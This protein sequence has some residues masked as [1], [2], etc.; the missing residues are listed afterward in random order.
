MTRGP[1]IAILSFHLESNAF[2]PPS[3]LEDFRQ[4]CWLEGE[5][6]SEHARRL[7]HMPS[8]ITGFYA[9]M[10]AAGPWQPLPLV[11]AAAPPGGPVDEPTWQ[12]FLDTATARLRAALPVD[13][14]YLGNHGAASG[15]GQGDTEAELMD[16]VRAI[17]GPE[18]PLIA[19]YDLHCNISDRVIHALDGLF[20]YR[21]NP[22]VDLRQRAADAA[23]AILACLGG[24]RLQLRHVRLPFTPPS[25]T[26]LTARGP[27]ADAIGWADTLLREDTSGELVDV[28][29]TGGFVFSDVPQCGMCVSVTTRGDPLHAERTAQAL[30]RRIWEDRHRYLVVTSTVDEAVA[31][32]RTST[33]PLLF[34][35]VADNPGGGGGGNTV[36]LMK[37]FHEARI[38]GVVLGVFIDADAVQQAVAAGVGGTAELV[39]NRMPSLFADTYAAT[40]RV[41]M[42]SDGEGTGRR[43]ILKDRRFSLGAS[44]LVEL[45]PSG[46]RVLVSSLRR[47]LSEP[48]MLEMHGI[49][50]AAA[51]VLIV[52]SRGH[53]RAGFDE[54][55]SDDRIVDVDSDGL[56]TP[57]LARVPFRHLPRPV[58]PLDADTAWPAS[59]G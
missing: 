56:T 57:N 14:V 51:R 49:D 41:L 2:S 11:I 21:T 25:V 44:A 5:A 54:F 26:L 43:G 29:V 52:K 24:E 50:I 20:P 38:P 59:A 35:D 48:A 47:Q 42:L 3:R 16:A 27:F 10:D 1:R 7:N 9:R 46:M 4:L 45:L 19:S 36:G 13:A 32:A 53:Y 55:F 22:H 17:V 58:F 31:Q 28:S 8:E 23:D 39:F 6:V 40:A 30:A 18:V 15:L 12:L 37:A 34:A 33:V